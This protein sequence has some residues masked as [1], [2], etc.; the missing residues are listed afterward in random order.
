[1]IRA[2]S[3]TLSYSSS[4]SLLPPPPPSCHSIPANALASRMLSSNE[5]IEQKEEGDDQKGNGSLIEDRS[6]GRGTA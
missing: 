4:F 6:A 3:D 1:M 2:V 5:K